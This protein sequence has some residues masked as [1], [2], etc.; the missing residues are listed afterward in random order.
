MK[1]KKL[2]P[3]E[4]LRFVHS[5]ASAFSVGAIP[6]FDVKTSKSKNR[7]YFRVKA[8]D[9]HLYELFPILGKIKYKY[10]YDAIGTFGGIDSMMK[11][12]HPKIMLRPQTITFDELVEEF[13]LDKYKLADVIV[14]RFK[15]AISDALRYDWNGVT[16]VAFGKRLSGESPYFEK[17][18][19]KF[20]T[21]EVSS[22]EEL[23]VWADLNS[24]A[25]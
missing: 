21:P 20:M 12:A 11:K 25:S 24:G 3:E 10:I 4:A 14:K 1:S 6:A 5:F 17:D 9:G 2:T 13:S 22:I 19:F 8:K 16:A 7:Y 15:R 23:A 18:D